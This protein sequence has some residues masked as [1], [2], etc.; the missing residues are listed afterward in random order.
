MIRIG[1]PRT[2]LPCHLI[3]NPELFGLPRVGDAWR[4][5]IADNRIVRIDPDTL[6]VLA[7]IR[8]VDAI[9]A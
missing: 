5:A 1:D 7:L 8:M 6:Q 2:G 4:Y 3:F 9:L